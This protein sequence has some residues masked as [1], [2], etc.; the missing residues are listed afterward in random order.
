MFIVNKNIKLIATLKDSWLLDRT[1]PHCFNHYLRDVYGCI[2][3]NEYNQTLKFKSQYHYD[4]FLLK[5]SE[6]CK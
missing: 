4:L 5:V 1:Y 3:F 2:E 6:Y